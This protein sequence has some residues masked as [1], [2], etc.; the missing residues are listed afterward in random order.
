MG[1]QVVDH[2]LI[3]HK[4]GL[5][6]RKDTSISHFRQL[7]QEITIMLTYEATRDLIL[8]PR[9]VMTWQGKAQAE[10]ISGKKISVVPIL[11]AGLGMLDGV[12][13]LIPSARV[14]VVGLYRNEE[15]LYPV[16][17]YKKFNNDIQIRD[18]LI[19]DPMLATGHSMA[20][21]CEM[22]TE[23]GCSNIKALCMVA[24]PEGVQYMDEHFP[25]VTIYAAALD[26]H[27]NEDGYIIPGL[28]DAGDRIFGT[29]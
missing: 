21:V 29:K 15:T 2:P 27:L 3:K 1:F 28:G 17:Y 25:D 14:N 9:S 22:L 23:E 8:E 26:D 5:L 18:A 24:A 19:I 20:R 13:A 12:L 4:L 6:R 10:R 7:T 11:R 16:E